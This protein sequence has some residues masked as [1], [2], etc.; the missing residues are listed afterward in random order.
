METTGPAFNP[1]QS[2]KPLGL[3]AGGREVY[4]C[5]LPG[6]RRLAGIISVQHCQ[7]SCSSKLAPDG[8]DER[9]LWQQPAGTSLSSPSV[10]FGCES[11]TSPTLWQGSLLSL[12]STSACSLSGSLNIRA[13][14]IST[15]ALSLSLHP[16]ALSLSHTH[17]CELSA[18]RQGSQQSPGETGLV[19]HLF[20]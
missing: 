1:W 9:G 14:S 16:R 3:P 19:R 13:L 17:L 18:H 4:C 12:P 7:E 6:G 10:G 8:W 5:T 15:S 2:V 20:A 11:G